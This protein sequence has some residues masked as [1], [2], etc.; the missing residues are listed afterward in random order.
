M[1]VIWKPM[2]QARPGQVR[3]SPLTLHHQVTKVDPDNE[4][5]GIGQ[6]KQWLQAPAV[7]THI[8]SLIALGFFKLQ[9]D[10]RMGVDNWWWW[11]LWWASFLPVQLIQCPLNTPCASGPLGHELEESGGE[12]HSSTKNSKKPLCIE[13]PIFFLLYSPPPQRW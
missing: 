13:A 7:N 10:S 11:W 4:R 6:G 9:R 1:Y 2:L 3:Q 8:N 5:D 12:R